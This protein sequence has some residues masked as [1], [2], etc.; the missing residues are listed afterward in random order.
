MAEVIQIG[1]R[2]RSAEERFDAACVQVLR[3]PS[4]IGDYDRLYFSDFETC[5]MPTKDANPESEKKN[6]ERN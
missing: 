5:I 4:V 2:L 1:Q 3:G 6:C